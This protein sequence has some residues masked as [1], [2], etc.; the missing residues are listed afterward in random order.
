[1]KNNISLG[2]W[3]TTANPVFTEIMAKSGFEWLSIDLEHS[4]ISI[5][6]V[7]NLIRIIDL[8]NIMPF[9]RLTSNNP[10]QIK[11]VLDFGAHGIIVPNVITKLDVENIINASFYPPMGNRGAGLARAQNYGN[12]FKEYIK[13][14]NKSLKIFVQIEN[15]NAIKNL[16]LIFSHKEITGYFIGPYDL[17]FSMNIPGKFNDKE[18]LKVISQINKIGKKYNL[19]RGIHV[20]EPELNNLKNHIKKG[21]DFIAYSLDTKILDTNCRNVNLAIKKLKKN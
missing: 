11:R 19:K 5:N 2:S 21:F 6:D 9:V 12:T 18:Y 16:D 7:E 20:V 10:D 1:M 15:I 17:S 8:N 14:A 4:S 13:K 3:I